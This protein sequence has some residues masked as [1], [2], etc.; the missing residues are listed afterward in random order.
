MRSEGGGG[1]DGGGGVEAWEPARGPL[2]SMRLAEYLRRILVGTGATQR[3]AHA[4]NPEPPA[5]THTH[6]H[7]SNPPCAYN[8]VC[9]RPHPSLM[10]THHSLPLVRRLR[11]HVGV[12][13]KTSMGGP[14]G[15]ISRMA[16]PPPPSPLKRQGLTW[17]A[18]S[19]T[20]C[21]ALTP[22]QAYCS[23]PQASRAC[24]H[25]HSK[26]KAV[27]KSRLPSLVSACSTLGR[28]RLKTRQPSAACR[29]QSHSHPREQ[30]RK[31]EHCCRL[32]ATQNRAARGSGHCTPS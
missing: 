14:C 2:G 15:S 10:L 16:S 17:G 19:A 8:A 25:G 27:G 29:R 26:K 32:W 22:P 13:P 18:G 20:P 11:R 12:A 3:T 4:A 23:C 6:K 7:T 9:H 24:C 21:F 31:G 1:G 5:H 28:R 30:H